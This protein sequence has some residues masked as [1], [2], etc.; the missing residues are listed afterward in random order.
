[1]V[2]AGVVGNYFLILS[3]VVTYGYYLLGCD[4]EYN[5]PYAFVMIKLW[6]SGFR[7][8]I[9]RLLRNLQMMGSDTKA[10]FFWWMSLDGIYHYEGVESQLYTHFRC[11]GDSFFNRTLFPPFSYLI[12]PLYKE[13]TY[14]LP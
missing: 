12:Y 11:F 7:H 10:M 8:I 9:K 2:T 13:L 6:Y 3:K 5:R 4:S 1:M 14:P